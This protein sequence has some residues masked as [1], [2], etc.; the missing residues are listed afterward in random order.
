MTVLDLDKWFFAFIHVLLTYT[1]ITF[2]HIIIPAYYVRG[3]VKDGP[4]IYRLNGLRVFL[5]T[6]LSFIILIHYSDIQFLIELR[7][8]HAICACLLG[9]IFSFIVVL[10]YKQNS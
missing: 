7:L 1:F 2:L 4:S 5:I 3:Y 6:I 10:P 9:I 8:K